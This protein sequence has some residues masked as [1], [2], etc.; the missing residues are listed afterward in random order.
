[1][2]FSRY[3]VVSLALGMVIGAGAAY[4]QNYPRKPIRLVTAEPG[5]GNDFSARL[6][7]QGLGGSLGQPMIV[8]NRGGA[9]GVIAADIVAKA[10]PDGYTLLLYANNIWIIPLLTSNAPFDVIRDFAPITWAAKSPNIMVVHPA[11]PVKSVE[12]LIARAKA[13][14][15]ELNYGSGGNGSSTHLA[16]ELF[17][18]MAGVNIVRVPFKGNSPALNAMFAG[19]VH[20]MIVT[21]GTV[22]PH[23]KSGRLRA[24]AVTSA[25]PSPLAPGLPT[26]AASGLPGYESI[27]IYGVFAP[28]KTDNAIVKRLNE[29]IVRVLERAEVKE[30]FLASGVEPVG[31]TPQLLAS[32][33]KS[34][35]AR[36]GKVIKDAGIRGE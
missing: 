13:R 2:K 31:S 22:A 6:I 33:I 20:L 10:Q 17:K 25:Q 18:S 35:I 34:E 27:Q 29:E 32:T 15:G 16:A 14:P 21:A 24:L 7:V 11:V 26:M 19:E 5:G 30:K 4:G 12:E 3:I 36:M 23:L 8:D 1:M 28:R 9:G